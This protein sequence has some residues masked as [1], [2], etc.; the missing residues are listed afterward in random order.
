MG[1]SGTDQGRKSRIGAL[2]SWCINPRRGA[3]W[4][5]MGAAAILFVGAWL[6]LWNRTRDDIYQAS[7][8]QLTVEA[9]EITPTPPWIRT[10]IARDVHCKLALAGWTST[11]DPLLPEKA[12]EAFA[13]HPW[14]AKVK[15]VTVVAGPRLSA[16]LVYRKP[17]CMVDLAMRRESILFPVDAG[18]VS[19]PESDFTP[20][21]KI[22]YLRL[23][24]I[25]RPEGPPP[26]GERWEDIRVLEAA[27]IAELFE[28]SAKKLDLDRI[29]PHSRKPGQYEYILC[30]RQGTCI[31]WGLAPGSESPSELPAEEK[32]LKLVTYAE[33][34]GSLQGPAGDPQIINIRYDLKTSP[35]TVRSYLDELLR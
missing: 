9:V 3:H 34:H 12:G 6:I 28:K 17:A 22:H 7:H 19:L 16:E 21:E 20:A 11:L 8:Y 14:V 15:R 5:G 24:G 13:S 32:I 31:E 33:K 35:R 1:D 26:P 23:V 29:V 4:M 30:T 18:G 25:E 2:L 10:D 27:R